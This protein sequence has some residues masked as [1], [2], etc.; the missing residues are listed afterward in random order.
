MRVNIFDWSL[1]QQRSTTKRSHTQRTAQKN[2]FLVMNSTPRRNL[3][4]L[5][6]NGGIGIS[7]YVFF[8]GA[9]Q[10]LLARV[11]NRL[12]APIKA[13]RRQG[14]TSL[15]ASAHRSRQRNPQT[16]TVRAN[17]A[18][19]SIH[20]SPAYSSPVIACEEFSLQLQRWR[21]FLAR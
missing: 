9:V 2:V 20:S 10:L 5:S 21:V 13:L 7:A 14:Q 8:L 19:S 11:G 18:L 12:W 15:W 4:W 16:G 1:R 3:P 6:K 17:L